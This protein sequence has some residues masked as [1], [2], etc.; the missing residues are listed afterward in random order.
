MESEAPPRNTSWVDVE[1]ILFN[2]SAIPLPYVITAFLA[3]AV[4]YSF[5]GPKTNIPMMN[6]KKP[7]ELS[8][9]RAKQVYIARGYRMLIEWFGANPQKPVRVN[10]DSD[11]LLVLP[12]SVTNESRNDPRLNF[13]RFTAKVG[14]WIRGFESAT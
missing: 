9:V 1:H 11:E 12:P 7:F 4:L 8:V 13:G 6:P 5:R 3:L 14:N 2:P 10:A